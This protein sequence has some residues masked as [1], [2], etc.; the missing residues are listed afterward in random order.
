MVQTLREEFPEVDISVSPRRTSGGGL[1]RPH[2]H[3]EYSLRVV[4]AMY[5]DPLTRWSRLGSTCTFTSRISRRALPRPHAVNTP[6]I[7]SLLS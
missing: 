3:I 7:A 1:S 2:Y 6:P 5:V 4:D